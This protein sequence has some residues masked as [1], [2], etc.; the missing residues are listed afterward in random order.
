MKNSSFRAWFLSL[1]GF[2]ACLGM[3]F[4]LV[5]KPGPGHKEKQI[6]RIYNAV[7][8]A[9]IHCYAME[10]RYPPSLSYMEEVY[11]LQIDKDAFIVEYERPGGN[12]APRIEVLRINDDAGG[13]RK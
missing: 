1:I 12:I 4:Y 10:G 13:R 9:T 6:E 5:A 2:A 3:L 7:W 8:R 11:G